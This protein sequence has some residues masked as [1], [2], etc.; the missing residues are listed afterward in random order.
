[1][2]NNIW[3]CLC[4]IVA[5]LAIVFA[6]IEGENAKRLELELSERKTA[7]AVSNPITAVA[8]EYGGK[9]FFK[10]T[11]L[12]AKYGDRWLPVYVVEEITTN[13][14]PCRHIDRT[15]MWYTPV[16]G[17]DVKKL[18]EEYIPPKPLWEEE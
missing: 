7:T 10:T 5:V 2:N 9:G 16:G 13:Y 11:S 18:R 17:V 12:Y 6:G 3:I 8:I 1:M 15:G 14:P 4:V